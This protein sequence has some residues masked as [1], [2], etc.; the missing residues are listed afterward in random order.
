MQD[1]PRIR[2]AARTVDRRRP[3]LWY[4]D[5]IIYQTLP[6]ARGS[7]VPPWPTARCDRSAPFRAG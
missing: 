3:T 7:V 2:I 4:K 5:A 1:D 6:G